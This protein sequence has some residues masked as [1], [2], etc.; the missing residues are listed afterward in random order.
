MACFL[1][2][3]R[4]GQYDEIVARAEQ[5]VKNL[6]WTEEEGH[7]RSSLSFGGAGYGKHKRPDLS[8][9]SYF[10][11]ALR[12]A[13]RG[14]EDEAIQRALH[15]VTQCQNHESKLNKAPFAAKNPDGG[16]Y[17][18]P[19]AGGKS[20]AGELPQG[21]LRSYGSMTY[22]GLKSMIY[23]G[24]ASDDRRV[25]AA[26][27]WIGEHY[28]LKTN[29]GMGAAGLYYYYHTFAKALSAMG[30]DQV[31]DA[32][33]QKHDWRRELVEILAEKQRLDGSWGERRKS[34]MV[35]RGSK[36]GD[37]AIACWL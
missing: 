16:F 21:G 27:R 10:I 30:V 19:A 17:Y 24:V 28:D 22:A 33:G 4:D 11:D 18:T 2:A 35:R 23:A 29:P 14:A 15:F 32:G 34:Q 6:Q 1:Q 8:N 36:S 3:N 13:G 7:D 9:T 25:Q 12:A 37:R 20:Q 31:E 5:F 26:F